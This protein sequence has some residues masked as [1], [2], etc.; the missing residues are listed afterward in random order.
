[1]A[2]MSRTHNEQGIFVAR[3][4]L[5]RPMKYTHSNWCSAAFCATLAAC[6]VVSSGVAH[7]GSLSIIQRE[8]DGQNDLFAGNGGAVQNHEEMADETSLTGS[9][10]FGDSGEVMVD[11][12]DFGSDGDATAT[13]SVDTSDSVTLVGGGVMNVTAVASGSSSVM[14]V[15]GPPSLATSRQRART[16]VRF[17]VIGTDALYHLTGNFT[18]TA[19]SGILGDAMRLRLHRPFTVNKNSTSTAPGPSTSRAHSWPARRGS[20]RCTSTTPVPWPRLLP[21]R[22]ATISHSP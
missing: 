21:I 9:F 1:M 10:T 19:D 8:S 15:S 12:S 13:G 6:L 22:L 5:W 16:R 7:G 14:T 2:V 4:N 3:S 20:S 18:P 17:Q 11:E